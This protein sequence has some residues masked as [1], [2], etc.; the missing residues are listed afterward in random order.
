MKLSSFQHPPGRIERIGGID[1]KPSEG[2]VLQ[3][4]RIQEQVS[5][6][7][8]K[9]GDV[10][11]RLIVSLRAGVSRVPENVVKIASDYES[12]LSESNIPKLF[13]NADPGSILVGKTRERS[14]LWPNQ[15]EVM[16]KGGHFIQEI[17]PHEIGEHLKEFLSSLG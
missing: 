6:F 2:G 13:I 3:L 4:R 17:S 1:G 16:V 12:F 14:R 7:G 9:I 8:E 10:R 11:P 5:A 15:K